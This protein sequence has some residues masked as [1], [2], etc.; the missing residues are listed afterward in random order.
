MY[1]DTSRTM[2]RE[3]EPLISFIYVEQII[4]FYRLQSEARTNRK[5]K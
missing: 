1:T 3:H 5:L 4:P 2:V